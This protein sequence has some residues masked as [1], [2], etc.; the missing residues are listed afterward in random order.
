MSEQD[1]AIVDTML[2]FLQ[3]FD[4]KYSSIENPEEKLDKYFEFID[5]WD[6]IVYVHI[7][8]PEGKFSHW[9]I[10]DMNLKDTESI[11]KWLKKYTE[12][13]LRFQYHID[14]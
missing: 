5:D 8:T 13:V 6:W 14:V 7:K 1:L 3:E 2:N 9:Y 11:V 10:L 4:Y 12:N